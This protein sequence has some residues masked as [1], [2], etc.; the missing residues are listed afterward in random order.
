MQVHDNLPVRGLPEHEKRGSKD[1][2][3]VSR[4]EAADGLVESAQCDGSMVNLQVS[5]FR[6]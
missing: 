4:R 3:G 6:R 5:C 2:I 1:R